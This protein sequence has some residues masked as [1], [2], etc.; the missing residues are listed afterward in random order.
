[1]LWLCGVLG[2]EVLLRR[3]VEK[4]TETNETSRKCP[5]A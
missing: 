5:A 3:R 4:Q 2:S 1:V